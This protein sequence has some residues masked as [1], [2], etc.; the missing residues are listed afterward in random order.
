[1][2]DVDS[3]APSV[4][5]AEQAGQSAAFE[6]QICGYGAPG[7]GGELEEMADLDSDGS[8]ELLTIAFTPTERAELAL[9]KLNSASGAYEAVVQEPLAAGFMPSADYGP[10]TTFWAGDLT[11][12]GRNEAVLCVVDVGA[13][14]FFLGFAA[15]SYDGAAGATLLR[16]EHV[17]NGD[18]V[19]LGTQLVLTDRIDYYAGRCVI[20]TTRY[21]EWDGSR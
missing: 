7:S 12:D 18:L 1:M 9:S 2:G 14:D 10:F 11:G 3:G 13:N 17:A 19:L 6:I 4:G 5:V 21:F 15:F 8:P 20:R 16:V